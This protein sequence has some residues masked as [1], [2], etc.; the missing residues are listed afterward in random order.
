MDALQETGILHRLL[1]Q[2][3]VDL[4]S[5]SIVLTGLA[6][7]IQRRNGRNRVADVINGYLK[8]DITPVCFYVRE[9]GGNLFKSTVLLADIVDDRVEISARKAI[10]AFKSVNSAFKFV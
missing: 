5:G 8:N 1:A 7:K 2:L 9:I 6:V 10:Y 3:A 4:R